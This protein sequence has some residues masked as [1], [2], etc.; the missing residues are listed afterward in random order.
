MVAD[1]LVADEPAT[2]VGVSMVSHQGDSVLT[3]SASGEADVHT[4]A[5][6]REQLAEARAA[7][8]HALVLDVSGLVFCG[9]A[10][11]DV[12]NEVLADGRAAGATVT[13]TGMSPQLAWLRHTFPCRDPDPTSEPP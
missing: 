13:I 1:E 12:L 9:L 4:A 2:P 5:S 8:P 6:W 11:L 7:W 3:L 10:G